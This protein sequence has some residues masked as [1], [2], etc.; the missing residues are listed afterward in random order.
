I[1]YKDV[2]LKLEVIPLINPD[3]DVTLKIAQ[4]NDTVIGNQVVAQNDVPI[5]GTEQL[6]TTVTVP[7]GNTIVIGGLISEQFR[8]DTEGIPILGRI[9]GLGRLFR[10]DITTK[11]RKEL[12]IFIQPVVVN[13]DFAMRQA[14][15]NED[16]RTKAGEQ[17]AHAFPEHLIPV[18][19]PVPSTPSERK[20]RWYDIF[21]R[22]EKATDKP[23]APPLPKK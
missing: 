20:H 3:G 17:A 18:A 22:T 1:E 13:E 8:T 4:I 7:T 5:I 6:T 11:E 2:V 10:E 16:L 14:S 21:K 23:A 9:P 12:I 19:Q 15:R